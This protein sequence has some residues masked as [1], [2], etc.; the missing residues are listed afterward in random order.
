MSLVVNIVKTFQVLHNW[1]PTLDGL[2][3]FCSTF[4]L[5]KGTKVGKAETNRELSAE[6]DV[7][8]RSGVLY[9]SKG[10]QKAEQ[11]KHSIPG[12]HN[13]PPPENPHHL[14]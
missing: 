14:H 13:N 2:N 1:I 9:S 6:F 7:G 12:E 8:A 4:S 5:F 10:L 3:R 11:R